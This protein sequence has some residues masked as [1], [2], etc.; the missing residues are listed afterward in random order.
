M[1]NKKSIAFEFIEENDTKFKA[2][3]DAYKYADRFSEL[4]QAEHRHSGE[5]F[6]L[7]LE[8]V[9]EKNFY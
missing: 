4:S 1:L 7:K 5:F 3:L 2:K 6:L 9:L 8:K